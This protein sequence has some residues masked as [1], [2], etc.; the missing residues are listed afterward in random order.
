VPYSFWRPKLT[1]EELER[2][3][4][5]C[6]RIAEEKDPKIFDE[7]CRELNQLIEIKEEPTQAEDDRGSQTL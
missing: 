1:P 3:R 6:G 7:L 2:F 5:L 4:Y